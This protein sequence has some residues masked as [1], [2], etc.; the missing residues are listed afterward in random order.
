MFVIKALDKVILKRNDQLQYAISI[1]K[2]FKDI[3]HPFIIAL[4]WAFQ[5]PKNIYMVL[6]PFSD[7][8][9]ETVLQTRKNMPEEAAMFY[10]AE[11]VLAIEALHELNIVYK[12]LTLKN[13][14]IDM[15][16]HINLQVIG[17]FEKKD[18][19]SE[20][21]MVVAPE[22]HFPGASKPIDIYAIGV[23][24]YTLLV[25]HSPYYSE[26]MTAFQNKMKSGVIRYPSY[27]SQEARALINSL[28]HANPDRRP[29]ISQLKT[30]QY[31]SSIDFQKLFEKRL[32]APY[33]ADQLRKKSETDEITTPIDCEQETD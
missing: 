13:T 27:V 5:T 21:L 22:I 15:Y 1:C 12:E 9:L 29:T 17:L 3:K 6:D 32:T 26:D 33:S 18:G 24:L 20:K 31:F 23:C 11:I 8:N 14:L 16:G 7:G 25:G 19:K 30:H 4:N 28:M 2:T 10:V